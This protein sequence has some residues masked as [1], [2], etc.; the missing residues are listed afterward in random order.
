MVQLYRDIHSD[1][2]RTPR[3]GPPLDR[4]PMS[5]GNRFKSRQITTAKRLRPRR[6]GTTL[7]CN[8]ASQPTAVMNASGENC[9]LGILQALVTAIG[10]GLR[11]LFV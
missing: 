5:A 10:D 11:S 4:T 3:S 2:L 8:L 6:H 7:R 9:V 1:P